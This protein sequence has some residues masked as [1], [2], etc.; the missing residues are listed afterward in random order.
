MLRKVMSSVKSTLVYA[1]N[2]KP[3]RAD[4]IVFTSR[5]GKDFAGNMLRIL[6]EL[7]RRYGDKYQ[8]VVGLEKNQFGR[9]KKILKQYGLNSVRLIRYDSLEYLKLLERAA[10]LFNDTSFHMRYVK[11]PGQVYINTW[12]GTPLKMMGIDSPSSFPGNG[13]AMD[14]VQRNLFAADYLLFPSE[15]F[16][17]VMAN[18]YSLNGLYTGAILREGYPRNSIFF[19]SDSRIKTRERYGLLN[20][21][22]YVYMPT[23]REGNDDKYS[24][25][26]LRFL[27]TLDNKLTDNE[28]LFVKIHYHGHSLI[29]YQN[30]KHILE[31]PKDIETYE[32]LNTA[33]CL[34]S[35]YSSVIYDF[36][37]SGKK[38]I[39][40]TFDSE[41][42]M[43]ERGL[44]KQP[45]SFPFPVVDT[46]SK[47]LQ[48]LR[49]DKN[50]SDELFRKTFCACEGPD[51]TKKI[52][53]HIFEGKNCCQEVSLYSRD[54]EKAY[55]FVGALTLNGVTTSAQNIMALE[56]SNRLYY[57]SFSRKMLEH[58]EEHLANLPKHHGVIEISGSYYCTILEMAALALYY[59]FRVD[60]IFLR[61][62]IDKFFEREVSRTFSGMGFDTYIHFDGYGTYITGLLQHARGRRAIF[63]HND[64][65]SEMS[66]KKNQNSLGLRDAYQNYDKVAVVAEGLVDITAKI[67]GKR[68]NILVVQ[69]CQNASEIRARANKELVMGEH[70]KVFHTHNKSVDEFLS[71]HKKNIITIGRFSAE[72]RHE[73]LIEAFEKLEQPDIGLIIIGGGG[74]L[75]EKTVDRAQQSKKAKDIILIYSIPNPMPIMKRCDLFVL[76]SLYEGMPMVLYEAECL[77]IP[78]ITVDT[79]GCHEFMTKYDGT[80]VDDSV[81]GLVWGMKQGI[82]GKVRTLGINFDKYN[83]M[84]VEQFEAIFR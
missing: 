58:H 59:T 75:L 21:R 68:D 70:T 84:C 12:H 28:V 10:F 65:K 41:E 31:Y 25:T 5:N 37:A 6:I 74:D 50:Y 79:T 47:L 80:L 66:M 76:S 46:P 52:V 78:A 22:V 32:F 16:Q 26:L 19:D 67:S 11:R 43:K 35:D 72:K 82:D 81:S 42:Y 9:V 53:D 57:A 83:R 23:F 48:E 64:M 73:M 20:K 34:V 33:D 61:K 15:Y 56:N 17:N 71:A 69:N 62:T 4:L 63:V 51:S 29:K 55:L 14:N 44:Y 18:A 45:V 77:G 8:Y 13:V 3:L 40:L 49:T 27:K 60:N 2:K 30:Y 24:T 54:H 1:E 36:A 38:I 39:L 7:Y